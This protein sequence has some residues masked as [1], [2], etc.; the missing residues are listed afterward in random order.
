MVLSFL[1]V[2]LMLLFC[3]TVLFLISTCIGIQIL[4]HKNGNPKRLAIYRSQRKTLIIVSVLLFV[5]FI[6][7]GIIGVNY[8]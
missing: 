5:V 4:H 6:V 1:A 7:T 2:I 3:F 8:G